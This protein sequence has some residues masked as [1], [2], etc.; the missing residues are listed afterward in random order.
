MK[1]KAKVKILAKAVYQALVNKNKKETESIVDNF[2]AYLKQHH[3]LPLLEEILAELK[4]LEQA[5][6]NILAV[7]IISARALDKHSITEAIKYLQQ[8]STQTLEI[9]E[10]I[11]EQ[12]LGGMKIK[13]QDKVLDFSLKKQ[14]NNLNKSLVN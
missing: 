1:N 3:F 13:Y 9:T 12:L 6:K 8:T 11:D 4:V 14:I 5:D 7:E 10:T 2:V